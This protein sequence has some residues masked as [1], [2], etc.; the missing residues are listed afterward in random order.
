MQYINTVT[1]AFYKE[2]QENISLLFFTYLVDK[3]RFNFVSGLQK[4]FF[5]QTGLLFLDQCPF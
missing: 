3:S 1:P 2:Q 4:F 5:F